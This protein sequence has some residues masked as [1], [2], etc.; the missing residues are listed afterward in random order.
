MIH[1]LLH[2]PQNPFVLLI[3]WL[4]IH[5]NTSIPLQ[6]RRILNASNNLF[7]CIVEHCVKAQ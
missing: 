4:Q 3:Q 1:R 7:I 6:S 2:L 5:F